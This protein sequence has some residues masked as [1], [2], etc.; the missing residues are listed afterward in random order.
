LKT[1]ARVCLTKTREKGLKPTAKGNL[2]RNVCREA[3]SAYWGDEAV[4]EDGR[5]VHIGKEEDFSRLHVTRLVAELSGLIRKSRGRFILSRECR[6]RLAD[7]SLCGISPRL[8]RSYARDF[9]WAYRDGYPDL[10]IIQRS[11]LFTLYLL[12]LHGEDWQ[13]QVCYEDGFLRAFPKVLSEVVPTPYSTPEKTV[14]PC[15]GWRALVN[16]A[17]FLGLAEVEPTTKDQ[18]DGHYRVRK[19]PLLADAVRFHIPDVS[20]NPII[21]QYGN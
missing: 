14:R 16:F 19:R 9:N 3:A 21:T 13:P 5:F 1:R 15:Y 17:V 8:L 4:R 18:Y 10:G 11:F 6:T 12:H 2:P 20:G 7:H